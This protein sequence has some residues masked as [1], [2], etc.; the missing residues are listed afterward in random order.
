MPANPPAY[1][2]YIKDANGNI[3]W[4]NEAAPVWANTSKKGDDYL[5]MA[6]AI[7]I[8]AGTEVMLWPNKP[9]PVDDAPTETPRDVG[10]DVPF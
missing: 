7:D 4:K 6:F 8:P 3:D 2:A 5:S 1:R 9:K 10:G